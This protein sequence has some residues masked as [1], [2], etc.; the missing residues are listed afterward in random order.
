M[1]SG[2]QLDRVDDFRIGP[3]T[4]QV[5]GE[6]VLDL[7]VAWI[8]ML[9]EQRLGHQNEA[10]RA[11]PALESAAFDEGILHWIEALAAVQVLHGDDLGS[12]G[13][14]A[15][16]KT[17]RYRLVIDDHRAAAAQALAAAFTRS[18][19]AEFGL[20]DFDEVLLRLDVG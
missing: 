15:K 2:G 6:V 11:V 10:R 3:A 1:F 5:A 19:Q 9:L 8:G 20:Q 18:G 16:I 7:L 12:I 17:A 14:H 4:A 13:K